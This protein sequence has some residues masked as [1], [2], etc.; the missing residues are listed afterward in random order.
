MPRLEQDI[1]TC[2]FS[3]TGRYVAKRLPDRW[4]RVRAL[5]RTPGRDDPLGDRGTVAPLDY[6][7]PERQGRSMTGVR[8]LCNTC[9]IQFGRRRTTLE[10]AADNSRLL[11][12]A[13]AQAGE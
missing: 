8:V 7:R 3:G 12:E 4:V 5:T 6:S 9:W 1:G 10:Q 11:F 13:A 2:A